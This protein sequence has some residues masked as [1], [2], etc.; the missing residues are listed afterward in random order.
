MARMY[1]Q[2]WRQPSN[3]NTSTMFTWSITLLYVQDIFTSCAWHHCPCRC[4]HWSWPPCKQTKAVANLCMFT[5][6]S[7]GGAPQARKRRRAVQHF[8]ACWASLR[9]A[10]TFISS[11]SAAHQALAFRKL[12]I[13]SGNNSKT[14]QPTVVTWN[15]WQV[16]VHYRQKI[17]GLPRFYWTGLNRV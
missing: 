16:F 7:W 5:L 14:A 11:F 15:S 2:H 17:C 3:S 6:F 10:V 12:Y 8:L 4:G 9:R 1:I 13:K